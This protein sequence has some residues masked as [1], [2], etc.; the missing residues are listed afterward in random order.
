VA[1]EPQLEHLVAILTAA[2][3]SGEPC[4]TSLTAVY[5]VFCS[6]SFS[7]K[8]QRPELDDL[9]EDD[10]DDKEEATGGQVAERKRDLS[11]GEQ[12]A[13]AV[14]EAAVFPTAN[15]RWSRLS[16]VYF[17]TKRHAQLGLDVRGSLIEDAVV[18]WS[19]L[20]NAH[21]VECRPPGPPYDSLR[22]KELD[23]SEKNFV[24]G[25]EENLDAFYSNVLQLKPITH[26]VRQAISA[27]D[28][29]LVP[30]TSSPRV[31]AAAGV[32]QR[33][34]ASSLS[35]SPQQREALQAS[36][37]SLR[38]YHATA[39][40]VHDELTYP[41]DH[42]LER[43]TGG[44]APV[45]L[46]LGNAGGMPEL[47]L[48]STATPSAFVQEMAKLLPEVLRTAAAIAMLT[49]IEA[50]WSWEISADIQSAVCGRNHGL[51]DMHMITASELWISWNSSAGTGAVATLAKASSEGEKRPL[52]ETSVADLQTAMAH[53][54]ALLSRF[55]GA[56][57]R[58]DVGAFEEG[59]VDVD[60]A[61]AARLS[62]LEELHNLPRAA[63]SQLQ[64][65]GYAGLGSCSG[66]GDCGGGSGGGGSGGGGSGGGGS[67]GGGSGGGG[68]SSVRG[69]EASI[70]HSTHAFPV[71]IDVDAWEALCVQPTVV[72][73][74]AVAS[75]VEQQMN[76]GRW[77]EQ[78]VAG[79]LRKTLASAE[80]KWVNEE[81]ERGEPYDIIVTEHDGA[82]G[83]RN[84][85]YV[86]V[87]ATTSADK[88]YFEISIAELG[89]A[90]KHGAAYSLY[91]VFNANSEHAHVLKLHNVARSLTNGGLVLF[92]GAAPA[93]AS[94]LSA[95]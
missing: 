11:I 69:G 73:A 77:G 13:Q 71:R 90:L 9:Q 51:G 23:K 20:A 59:P 66:D 49:P 33:W 34:S 8:R 29:Q 24:R 32:L 54:L 37:V 6:W 38:L 62:R 14:G 16:D 55:N 91:R 27:L 79:H 50:I 94:G 89:F 31:C 5:R 25:L 92:A 76:T 18:R 61:L 19:T 85:S 15:G 12:I 30:V 72:Q 10:E 17:L 83:S 47:F 57:G 60:V 41:L 84:V 22:Q 81:E 93:A 45:F 4:A 26:F 3:K 56:D 70:N 68:S 42:L 78:L 44:D 1:A 40:T 36:L 28:A 88:P 21:A 43:S 63:P 7:E 74:M 2:G 58:G 65:I 64:N 53:E 82:S 86:E 87:K 35:C 95:A 52:K 67:G 48:T 80:V 75:S 39:I 46:H